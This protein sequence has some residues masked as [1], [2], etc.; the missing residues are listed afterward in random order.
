MTSTTLSTKARVASPL[1]SPSNIICLARTSLTSSSTHNPEP[2]PHTLPG[3]TTVTGRRP[4]P[5]ASSA[6]SS[7]MRLVRL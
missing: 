5:W 3:R 6:S 1:P 4:K 7:E 2:G